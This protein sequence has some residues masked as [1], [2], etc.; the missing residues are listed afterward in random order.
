MKSIVFLGFSFIGL[1]F[2]TSTEV[3]D[4]TNLRVKADAVWASKVCVTNM[5]NSNLF[6]NMVDGIVASPLSDHYPNN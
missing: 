1:T 5:S 2:S 6:W 4:R 3:N